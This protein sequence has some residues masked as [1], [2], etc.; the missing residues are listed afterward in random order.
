ML[1]AVRREA[2]G[3]RRIVGIGIRGALPA[4]KADEIHVHLLAGTDLARAAVAADLM[5]V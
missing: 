4:G 2:G 3:L 5:G 1:I